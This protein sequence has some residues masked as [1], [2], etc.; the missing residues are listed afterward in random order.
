MS[1]SALEN[2]EEIN[3]ALNLYSEEKMAKSRF[4]A[5]VA[6]AQ[7]DVYSERMKFTKQKLQGV[8][9]TTLSNSNKN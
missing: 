7:L 2:L 6:S 8:I 9:E 4:D 1:R 5:G 3:K